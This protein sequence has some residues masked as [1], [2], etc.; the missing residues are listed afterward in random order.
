[1]KIFLLENTRIREN[2]VLHHFLLSQHC[3]S[4]VHKFALQNC[5]VTN[6]M[7]KQFA[8]K[9]NKRKALVKFY[10]YVGCIEIGTCMKFGKNNIFKTD[11]FLQL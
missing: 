5:K 9:I 6:K 4:Q 7:V 11:D 1:M 10:F 8:K 2:S 3:L